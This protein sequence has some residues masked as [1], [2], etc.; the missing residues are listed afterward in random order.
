V[1]IVVEVSWLYRR[2]QLTFA[3]RSPAR[4]S[5]PSRASNEVLPLKGK[6]L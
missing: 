6:M 4:P 2:T 3:R 5:R 1:E